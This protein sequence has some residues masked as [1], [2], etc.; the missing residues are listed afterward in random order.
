MPMS[1]PVYSQFSPPGGQRTVRCHDAQCS[2]TMQRDSAAGQCSGTEQR[3]RAAG[4][5]SGA[6]QR[7]TEASYKGDGRQHGFEQRFAARGSLQS[8]AHGKSQRYTRQYRESTRMGGWADATSLH[9][10]ATAYT[11]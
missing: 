5:S 7:V 10:P 11:A 3:D 9:R 6:V 1:V 2:G 4:Q 8:H